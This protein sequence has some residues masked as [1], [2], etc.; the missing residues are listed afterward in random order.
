MF[1][2]WRAL[3]WA[4]APS[5]RVRRRRRRSATMGLKWRATVRRAEVAGPEPFDASVATEV[6]RRR[7]PRRP[8]WARPGTPGAPSTTF[9]GDDA[10]RPAASRRR[11]RRRRRRPHEAHGRRAPA[12][13]RRL[14]RLLTGARRLRVP[15]SRQTPASAQNWPASSTRKPSAAARLHA[16]ARPLVLRDA[17]ASSRA[18]VAR[19]GFALRAAVD[20]Q[21]AWQ[22]QPSHACPRPSTRNTA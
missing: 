12:T 14:A 22:L 11:R 19:R 20:V 15:Q 6:Q 8:I 1:C 18:S 13:P 10:R 17:G 3:A 21:A 7:A 2:V 16:H 9:R 4:G 5:S